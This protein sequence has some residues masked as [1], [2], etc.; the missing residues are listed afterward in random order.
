MRVRIVTFLVLLFGGALP[1]AL[2]VMSANEDSA[3]PRPPEVTVSKEALDFGEVWAQSDFE[4]TLPL[5]NQTIHDVV[6]DEIV[7]SCHCTRASEASVALAPGE[8]ADC[9]L[10]IDLLPGQLPSAPGQSREFSVHVTATIDGTRK[11][12]RRWVITGRVRD[13]LGVSAPQ[14]RFE[15]GDPVLRTQPRFEPPQIRFQSALQLVSARAEVDPPVAALSCELESSTSGFVKL[16]PAADL[17][18]GPLDAVLRIIATTADAGEMAVVSMP[19]SG[20]VLDDVQLLPRQLTFGA[21]PVGDVREATVVL[22]SRTGKEVV[23][24]RVDSASP[25]TAVEPTDLPAEGFEGARAYLVRQRIARSGGQSVEVE[26]V[27]NEGPARVRRVPLQIN[28]V[29]IADP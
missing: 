24:D 11:E 14:V 15:A 28:Y 9:R 26:F 12:R 29:G 16:Q 2:F 4:W 8:T 17:P 20:L 25:T 10:L 7:T 23:V 1:A 18:L 3:R 5:Q 22:T 6:V 19:V 27:V 13:A 21:T